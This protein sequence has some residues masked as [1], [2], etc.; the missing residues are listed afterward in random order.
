[1]SPTLNPIPNGATEIT[2]SAIAGSVIDI[3]G[4]SCGNSPV[5][6][7][8]DGQWRCDGPTPTPVTDDVVSVTATQSGLTASA[9]VTTTV[10][11]VS[12]TGVPAPQVDPTDGT[13][14]TGSTEPNYA[15]GIF[16]AT[17]TLVCT[18]TADAS[19]NFSC[20]PLSPAPADG[21]VLRVLAANGG[22]FSPPTFVTVDQ[23]A[24]NVPVITAPTDGSLTNDNTP[25]VTGTAEAGA[26]VVVMGPNGESCSVV[27]DSAGNWSCDVMPALVDGSNQL[28]ATASDP[29]GNTSAADSVTI[30]VDASVPPA[31]VINTPTNGAP[32]SGT[33]EPGATVSV[34]TPSGSTC[35]AIVQVDGSWSCSLSPTPVDGE[36]ITADQTDPAGNTSPPVTVTGG[37]D[38]TA[39]SDPVI[40]SP[41][42]GAL[43]SSNVVAVVG[44]GEAGS[45][46]TVSG[47]NGEMCSVEV[48]GA[49]NWSC[50]K[51][52]ALQDGVNQLNAV[53]TDEAGNDSN[54]DSV[55]ITIDTTA[56]DAPMINSP[57]NGAPVS[58]TGEPGATV[59]V[60]TPS[61][62]TC[63]ATVQADGSWLCTLVPGPQDGED[64]TATQTDAAGN[65]SLP[66]TVTG[67][68]DTVAPG[69]PVIISPVDGFVTNDNTPTVVGTA[70]AGATVVVTALNGESCSVVAD[71][72]GDW[73]C[74]VAPALVDGI[75]ALTAQA[76]DPA[77]NTSPTDNVTITVDTQAP[78]APV[79]TTPTN[80]APVSGTG[81]P[82]ATVTVTTPSGATCTA[83]VQVDGTWSCSLSPLPVDGED[84]TAIQADEAGNNSPPTTVPGGVDTSAPAVP[85]IVAPVAG[86]TIM[87]STPTVSG[88]AEA[89]ATVVV[90]GPNGETCSAEADGNGDW[91][92][93]LSPALPDGAVQ[94]SAVATDEA[95]NDSQPATVDFT[96]ASGTGYDVVITPGTEL[97][98]TEMGGTDTF[99]VSLT[100]TPTAD[101]TLNL[102]SSDVTEG[103]IDTSSITFTPANWN[104]PVTVT[105]T[106]VDDP[107]YDLDQSYQIVTA[108]FVSS[109]PNYDGIDPMDVDAINIDDDENADLSVFITNCVV[110]V[111]PNGRVNY[112]VIVDN[113]GNKDITGLVVQSSLTDLMTEPQWTC[114]SQTGGC[115]ATSGSGELNEMIDLDVGDQVIYSMRGVVTAQLT[116]F[117]DSTATVVMPV[118]E[119]DTD[120][121]NNVAEDSDLTIQFLFKDNFDCDAPGTIQS[122]AEQLESWL[123][124]Q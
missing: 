36:D 3:A 32:V 57:T 30:M 117:L 86:S 123:L 2:G 111:T 110:D 1:M 26:T 76:T 15:I 7:A 50:V 79:I 67:G 83:T 78:D 46:I 20:A 108:A 95:G 93:D 100:L 84:I 34:T 75:Q 89:G 16:N 38:T 41:A 27:A 28:D 118:G 69:A 94:L 105:V 40:T 4:I 97:V 21:D 103:T 44:T 91:S 49:G 51:S 61:G 13:V 115:G 74:D 77:G 81:E 114:E 59:N 107:D 31:P 37:I 19:G 23:T 35:T 5:T 102:S 88:T 70:E 66:T 48:D 22:Q 60:T 120:P 119:T 55:T 121:S 29:V 106:G 6:A 42:D 8:S 54:T 10:Y 101:V 56:P 104:V 92:C 112:R 122:T 43:L 63:T 39:P 9:P 11:E 33:G 87:D 52:P 73:S 98:T 58:G 68:I 65:V 113:I 14:V 25:T 53:A 116:D 85:T 90:T 45:T 109:D 24:P 124:Q 64:I 80:G 62:A 99:T 82:G 12:V 18:T 71:N 72:N 17:G 96:V 47:P